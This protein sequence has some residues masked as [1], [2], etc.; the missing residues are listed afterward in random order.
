MSE[1][2]N[3]LDY[4]MSSVKRF[5]SRVYLSDKGNS[6]TYKEAFD[7]V[8]QIS[9]CLAMVSE[10]QIPVVVLLSKSADALLT[11]HA[12]TLAGMI[13]CP[14]DVKSPVA[15]LKLVLETLGDAIV[16][17]SDETS[18][19]AKEITDPGHKTIN[20][21]SLDELKAKSTKHFA[22]VRRLNVVSTDPCYIIFTSGSTGVP[23][24]VTVSHANVVDYIE[25]AKATYGPLDDERILSQAPFYFDNSTLDIYLAAA[26]SSCLYL[27]EDYDYMFP[28]KLIE[29]LVEHEV[30]LVFWVPSVLVSVAT[31]CT[32]NPNDLKCL[33]WV[34]FAGEVMPAPHLKT[35]LKAL[36]TC[37]FSNLYGPTEITVDCTYFIIPEGWDG[38]N[39]PI[40]VACENTK[41][42][43]LDEDGKPSNRG[44]LNVAGAGVSLG[45]WNNSEQTKN[46]FIQNPLQSKFREII[47]KTGDVVDVRDG[48]IYFIGR[49]DFQVKINGYR[50]E[51]GEIEF[52]ALK[53]EAVDI[54]VVVFSPA[55]GAI[56]LY[57]E[58]DKASEKLLKK[59][60]LQFIPKYMLPTKIIH[61]NTL[62]LT[63]NGKYNRLSLIEEADNA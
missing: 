23:K 46:A 12:A 11:I 61:K 54:P 10:D 38:D 51:L 7:R 18:Q 39:V 56:V 44:E 49:R 25:W 48:L 63:Q 36:P 8:V 19:L 2:I 22:D 52:A 33:K 20:I 41:L 30:T 58:G 27:I 43:V 60:L 32:L 4:F 42:L 17:Y 55:T 15:R 35:L 16:V 24:G 50:V 14:V 34:L 26:T 29:R 53:L 3:I 62:P 59:Q 47:Y 40:G 5:P 28:E 6:F 57:Y 13:Y 21:S 31:K 45:Y 37:R 1:K 9:D